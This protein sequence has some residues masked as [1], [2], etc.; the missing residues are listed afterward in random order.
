[1]MLRNEI[2]REMVDAIPAEQRGP[3]E[4]LLARQE[5]WEQRAAEL[6]AQGEWDKLLALTGSEGRAAVLCRAAQRCDDDEL[7]DLLQG[8]WSLTEAWSGDASLR[9]PLIAALRR[10]APVVAL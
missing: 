9:D 5:A 2:T 4:D 10:V 7:R 6:E 3:W 1:M 8:Y